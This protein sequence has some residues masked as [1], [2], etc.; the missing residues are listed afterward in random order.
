MAH[1]V[2]IFYAHEDYTTAL[3]ACAKLEG[4]RRMRRTISAHPYRL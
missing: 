1:D 3:A 4:S 2:F